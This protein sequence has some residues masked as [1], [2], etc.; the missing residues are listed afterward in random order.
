MDKNKKI[1]VPVAK[2]NKHFRFTRKNR[3]DSTGAVSIFS[4]FAILY[5]DNGQRDFQTFGN[6][7]ADDVGVV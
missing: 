4:M 2:N 3:S 7:R 5:A 6:P 1:K